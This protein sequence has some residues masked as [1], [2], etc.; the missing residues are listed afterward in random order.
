MGAAGFLRTRVARRV[1]FL[2]VLSAVLPVA[3]MASISF[4]AVNRQLREQSEVRLEQ[5]AKNA[6]QSI[7]QQIS[8]L[9]GRL[10]P[11]A[12]RAVDGTVDGPTANQL[13]P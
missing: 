1:V 8:L 6:G 13:L 10:R 12:A 9:E 2:F 4:A 11:V 5:L 7:L 3:T